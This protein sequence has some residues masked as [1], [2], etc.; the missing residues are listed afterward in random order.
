ME[1]SLKCHWTLKKCADVSGRALHQCKKAYCGAQNS[2]DSVP[3]W[4]YLGFALHAPSSSEVRVLNYS[5][6]QKDNL[7][8]FTSFDYSYIFIEIEA[9]NIKTR[10]NWQKILREYRCFTEG[11][12]VQ[13]QRHR[14]RVR[15]I[16]WFWTKCTWNYSLLSIFTIWLLIH[17]Y[18]IE[19]KPTNSVNGSTRATLWIFLELFSDIFFSYIS[20]LQSIFLKV[21]S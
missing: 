1:N 9:R 10:L 19:E 4:P 11:L 3:I 15:D 6:K 18:E 14:L 5:L 8:I 20:H 16:S 12:E 2:L 21:H 7:S 13:N 17:I